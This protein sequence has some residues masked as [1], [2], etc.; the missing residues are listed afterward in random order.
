MGKLGSQF[1]SNVG[2]NFGNNVA[3]LP[4]RLILVQSTSAMFDINN[5][6]KNISL[7]KIR[8]GK[9]FDLDWKL[10]VIDQF[11]QNALSL[12]KNKYLLIL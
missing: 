12:M 6:M 11:A 5:I 7:I 2:L 4:F 9:R 3:S 10:Y 1:E 8:S